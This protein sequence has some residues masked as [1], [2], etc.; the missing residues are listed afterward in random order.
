MAKVKRHISACRQSSMGNHVRNVGQPVLLPA[1][2]V[3]QLRQHRKGEVIAMLKSIST[4]HRFGK[5][6]LSAVLAATMLVMAGCGSGEGDGEATEITDSPDAVISLKVKAS[7]PVVVAPDGVEANA[8][9]STSS[10]IYSCYIQSGSGNLMLARSEDKGASW[11]HG[12][13]DYGGNFASLSVD[14]D[15]V[16]V[17]YIDQVWKTLKFASSNDSGQTWLIREVD[18]SIKSDPATRP[19]NVDPT[20][21]Y[22]PDDF[23]YTAME[24]SGDSF[25]IAYHDRVHSSLR[26][27]RSDD[28]GEHWV[29]TTLDSSDTSDGDSP[30]IAIDGAN[31]YI[32]YVGIVGA[33]PSARDGVFMMV[34]RDFGLTWEKRT[35]APTAYASGYHTSVAANGN[36]VYVS[37]FNA[38][39]RVLILARSADYGD[40]WAIRKVDASPNVGRYS[41]LLLGQGSIYLSYSDWTKKSL[42]LA[43]SVNGGRSW[44]K[45]MVTRNADSGGRLTASML[46][47]DIYF[48]YSIHD[49]LQPGLS[50]IVMSTVT[51]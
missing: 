41:S 18:I 45:T 14:G 30:S 49:R 43:K 10:A 46:N 29:E 40:N 31:I 50:G 36:F 22:V 7:I 27:A 20:Q 32:S 34:S 17:S 24:R 3:E 39:G 19:V 35:V 21:P 4:G 6:M 44:K 37:Y 11:R 9:E 26:L 8:I 33:W 1:L 51:N 2:Q 16:Y 5:V 13:I 42:K 28:R 15:K 23:K 47:D 25:F 48:L 12:I 38:L